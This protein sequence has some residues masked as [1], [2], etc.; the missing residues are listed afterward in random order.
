MVRW[1]SRHAPASEREIRLTQQLFLEPLESE[2]SLHGR[3]CQGLH[4]EAVR[5]ALSLAG[6]RA[7]S[8]IPS[9]MVWVFVRSVSPHHRL[10][11]QRSYIGTQNISSLRTPN[12]QP[13]NKYATNCQVANKY[14]TNCLL[15]NEYATNGRLANKYATNCQLAI[16]CA[17]NCQ[18]AD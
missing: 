5:K 13:A 18:L 3:S 12:C 1:A 16:K 17:M 14:A 8:L 2:M 4:L 7:V 6:S 9:T 11:C 10:Y 15:A